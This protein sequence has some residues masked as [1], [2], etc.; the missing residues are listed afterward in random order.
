MSFYNWQEHGGQHRLYGAGGSGIAVKGAARFAIKERTCNA[1][2][3]FDSSDVPCDE[4]RALLFLR[5]RIG[6]HDRDSHH[7]K[8]HEA[9]IDQTVCL[10][11]H[12]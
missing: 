1:R 6:D 11:L 10:G 4:K 8:K 9:T 3:P 12:T 2:G 7:P 5:A